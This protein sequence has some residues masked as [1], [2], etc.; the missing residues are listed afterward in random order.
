MLQIRLYAMLALLGLAAL[1]GVFSSFAWLTADA[2]VVDFSGTRPYAEG[3]ALVV[4]DAWVNGRTLSLP[5]A[6]GIDARFGSNSQGGVKFTVNSISSAGWSRDYVE[7]RLIETQ[8]VLVDANELDMM[9]AIPFSVE[10]GVP[11]LV[12][13]PSISPTKLASQLPALE[14]QE[15]PGA[16]ETIP[17]PVRERVVQWASAYAA[18]SGT[19]LRNLAN[20]VNASGDQYRGIG[21]LTVLTPPELKVAIQTG[22]GLVIRVRMNLGLPGAPSGF[23]TDLDVLVIAE[24]TQTPYVVAWGQAGSGPSL[25]PYQNRGM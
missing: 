3:Q 10:T 24:T 5:V 16:L 12:A 15:V 7:S 18:G 4:A 13:Y 21:A 23:M 20:D 2:P 17:T 6:E 1:L 25:V 8:Y 11:V 22:T 14:Y 9:L 19:D